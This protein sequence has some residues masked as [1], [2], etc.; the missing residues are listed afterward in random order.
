MDAHNTFLDFSIIFGLP[1]AILIY[2]IIFAFLY[3]SF[4]FKNKLIACTT[5][6]LIVF[7]MFHFIGRHFIFWFII[8]I[9]VYQLLNNSMNNDNQ[10]NSVL[11]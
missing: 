5:V 1:F 7:S 10:K 6:G 4:W 8:A 3:Q 2:G 9:M 11:T